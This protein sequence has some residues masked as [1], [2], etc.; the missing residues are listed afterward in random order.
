[1][2]LI[3][4]IAAIHLFKDLPEEHLDNLVMILTDQVFR[5]SQLIFSEG[6]QATGF[7]VVISG[8][9]KIFKLS[10]D[11]KEQI[12]HI[13]GP[14]APIGEVAV[15]EGKRFPANA[16]CLEE[17]RLFFFPKKAFLKLIKENPSIALHMLAVLSQRLRRFASL[18]DDLSLKEVPA[19]LAAYLLY[20][21]ET[22]PNLD[23]LSLDISKGQLSSLL[24]TVP[25]TLSRILTKMI[26]SGLIRSE[27]A[28]GIR[29]LDHKGLGD[30]ASGETRL[31]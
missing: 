12:L 29:I 14:G 23:N 28:R 8:R 10:M 13:F 1:V 15:F 21:S 31:H 18:I 19:R 5:K 6:D 30:L 25:E 3:S 22:Q 11:G 16:E 26:N 20:L 7:Y 24:G 9:V 17:S 27:G 2:E 4:H